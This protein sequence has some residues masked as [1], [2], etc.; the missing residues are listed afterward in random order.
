MD[1]FAVVKQLFKAVVENDIWFWYEADK[2]AV[3]AE[4]CRNI[5]TIISSTS[6]PAVKDVSFL[7]HSSNIVR[8]TRYRNLL[9]SKCSNQRVV[10]VNE[11]Y[12]IAIQWYPL[13]FLI[14]WLDRPPPKQSILD[15]RRAGQ[16]G[17]GLDVTSSV[18][19]AQ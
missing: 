2:A 18:R 16:M 14:V 4:L 8:R 11:Y 12:G 19:G 3:D 15:F 5:S 10:D 9:R 17:K 7:V 6:T 1:E 13:K